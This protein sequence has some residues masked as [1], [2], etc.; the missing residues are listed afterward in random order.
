MASGIDVI[1]L[2]GNAIIPEGGKGTIDEQR[3][4][5]SDTMRQVT[6]LIASGREIITPD[7]Y[8]RNRFQSLRR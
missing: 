5:T 8:L 7:Q 2:G 6:D 1:A 4:L 3:N